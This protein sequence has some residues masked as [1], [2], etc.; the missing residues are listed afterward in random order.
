MIRLMTAAAI[1]V[2][3]LFTAEHTALSAKPPVPKGPAVSSETEACIGCH[4]QV[5]PGIVADWR[6]S[7]HAVTLP[8]D[9]LRKPPL[10]RRVSA[11]SIPAP[12]ASQTVGCHECHS[13]NLDRHGDAFEHYGFRIQVVVS[14]ND[15]RTCHP[16]EAEQ[17]GNSKK[18]HA[19]KNLMDNPVYRLLVRTITGAKTFNR[20]KISTREPSDKTLH[21]TCLG[22]HGTVVEAKGLQK[23]NTTMGEIEVPRLTNWPNQ[24]VGRR[25]PDGSLGACS[26]CHPRHSFSIEIARKPHTCGQCHLEPDVPAYNVYKE[27]KHGNI[28]QSKERTWNFSNVPWVL[29]SDFT[30]PTCAACHN[31][32]ITSPSGD[33]IAERTHNF[34]DRLWVRIFGLPYAHP[35]PRSGNTTVIRNA[36]GQPLPT[37]FANV[38]A[39]S[40]LIDKAEQDK[41]KA[42][43]TGVCNACHASTW[44]KGHFD[45]FDNTVLETN[46]M[47]LAATGILQEAWKRGVEDKKNPF[48]ETIEQLWVRHWLFYGNS[49]RYASAMTGAPDYAAFKNGWWEL[50]RNMTVMKDTL[51]FKTLQKKGRK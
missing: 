44:T 51:D 4:E 18:A 5:T 48:D 10:Q 40:H 7:R 45:K 42:K 34:G 6:K 33:I 38:P 14:P 26:S 19:I 31:S 39:S 3:C 27:S 29:G 46:A 22:C 23:V 16:V 17:Y 13:L 8:S 11:K 25:N 12:L 15:C 32:L 47:T 20:G 28:Y 24:G 49:I 9:A 1:L 50:M 43:M 35:Q 2:L 30:A 36:D 21:E 37:T 41:R